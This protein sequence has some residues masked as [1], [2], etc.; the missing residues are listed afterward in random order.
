MRIRIPTPSLN[1]LLGYGRFQPSRMP[2]TDENWTRGCMQTFKVILIVPVAV[3]AFFQRSLYEF[4]MKHPELMQSPPYHPRVKLSLLLSYTGLMSLFPWLFIS[5]GLLHYARG[6]WVL[7][8]A[9][10]DLC[11]SVMIAIAVGLQA[12]YLPA[13]KGRCDNGN[14]ET[15]Q[16]TGQDKS[17]FVLLHDLNFRNSPVA[18]CKQ[19]VVNWQT[20]VACLFFQILV[21]YIGVFFDSRPRSLLNPWRPIFNLV[22]CIIAPWIFFRHSLLPS[23][24]YAY[25]FT[26]KYLRRASGQGSPT[27]SKPAPY[28]PRYLHTISNPKLHQILTIEHVLLN[29][30]DHMCYEDVVNF[31]LASKSNREAIFPGRDLVHRVPKLRSH[32]CSTI[33]KKHCQYCNKDICHQC[34]K[35]QILPGMAGPRHLYCTPYCRTCYFAAFS[36]HSRGYKRPCKCNSSDRQNQSQE[37]CRSCAKLDPAVM[38]QTRH[39]RYVQEVRDLAYSCHWS[40]KICDKCKKDLTSGMRW[41]VCVRCKGE[42]RDCIHPSYVGKK[43]DNDDAEKQGQEGKTEGEVARAWWRVFR[44]G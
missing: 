19:V 32:C 14:S 25:Q 23:L 18:A 17:F 21:S 40:M 6:F 26:F 1:F 5:A 30:V 13:T 39:R 29:I 35:P 27:F 4:V 22:I 42:C 37:M 9:L 31:S 3:A 43:K 28:T 11:L 15:W 2:Q 10:C 38:Q 41:W 24:R 12:E 16:V 33:S 36:M 44:G 7:L 8:I 34:W 20:V